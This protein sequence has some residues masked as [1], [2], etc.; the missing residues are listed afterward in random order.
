MSGSPPS[1]VADLVRDY[2]ERWT[3]LDFDGLADLWER[4]GPQPVYMGEEYA[5]PLIGNDELD[6]HWERI[7]GRIKAASVSAT[8]SCAWCCSAGS[9]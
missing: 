4:D 5:A 9:G 3:R 8:P 6:R 7:A 2:D 1:D